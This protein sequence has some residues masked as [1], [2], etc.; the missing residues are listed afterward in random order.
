MRFNCYET[1]RLR[2]WHSPRRYSSSEYRPRR[3]FPPP[4]TANR[5]HR[6]QDV[7]VWKVESRKSLIQTNHRV[8]EDAEE[9]HRKMPD[10]GRD[11]GISLCAVRA[12]CDS[13]VRFP[14]HSTGLTP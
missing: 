10:D 1:D 12:L 9:N 8:T 3:T 6:H 2:F 4:D 5:R 7:V 14:L 11:S 13:V